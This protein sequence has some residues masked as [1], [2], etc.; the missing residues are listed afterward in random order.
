MK[1][2]MGP[3][4]GGLQNRALTSHQDDILKGKSRLFMKLPVNSTGIRVEMRTLQTDQDLQ[5]VDPATGSLLAADEALRFAFFH[6]CPGLVSQA[7]RD[8][9]ADMKISGSET[10]ALPQLRRVRGWSCGRYLSRW[11]AA[12]QC[13]LQA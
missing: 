1:C 5:L 4:L 13:S 10:K 8:L 6:E 2:I 11:R 9:A 12:C 3:T 7:M